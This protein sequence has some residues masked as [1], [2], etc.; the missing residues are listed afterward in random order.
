MPYINK[1]HVIYA[2]KQAYDLKLAV[3]KLFGRGSTGLILMDGLFTYSAV[4]SFAK[5][6]NNML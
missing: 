2:Q 1:M 4:S 3:S 6:R 5:H